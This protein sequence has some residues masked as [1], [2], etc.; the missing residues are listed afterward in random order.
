[1]RRILIFDTTLRDGEKSPGTILTL[2]E[3]V[4]IAKQLA[5]LNVDI[6]EA[7]FPAASAEQYQAVER[8]AR[9]LQGPVI[10]ALAR[11]T[12][13]KDF[14]VAWEVLK[15]ASRPRIHTFVP[16]SRHY[17][18]HFLKKNLDQTRE[19]AVAGCQNGAALY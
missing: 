11:A 4:R 3:K 9:E 19:L 17:R 18:E 5:R 14:E 6:L 12:N 10:A 7:G 8:I 15:H 13:P 1:M 16:A 2:T